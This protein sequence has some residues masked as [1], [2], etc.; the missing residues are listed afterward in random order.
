MMGCCCSRSELTNDKTNARANL[1][2]V[3]EVGD[4]ETD[5]LNE[6]GQPAAADSLQDQ[7]SEMTESARD[8]SD[9]LHTN[10]PD[11]DKE[12]A[13]TMSMVSEKDQRYWE[14]EF[15]GT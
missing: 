14:Y 9:S 8:H 2:Q 13:L 6:G 10:S 11:S 1:I 7:L 12:R 15:K 3:T 5:L 4:S